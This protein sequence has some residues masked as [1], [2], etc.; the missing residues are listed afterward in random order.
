MMFWMD[1]K[2]FQNIFLDNERD[3]DILKAQYVLIST[4]IRKREAKIENIIT[5]NSILFPDAHVCSSL[6]D[7]DF[8]ERYLN[9][10][11]KNNPFIATLIKGSIEENYNIIFLCTKKENKMKYLQFLSNYIYLEFDYPVYEYKLYASGAIK[12][13]SYNKNKILKKCNKILKEAKDINYQKEIRTTDG[14]KRIIKDFKNM[15]KSDLKKNL[16]KRNLYKEGM[17]K[18]DMIEMIETFM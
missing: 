10:C 12:L 3:Q 2:V 8:K 17:S 16:K 15:K 11:S 6:T 1:S 13:I 5:A 4:R 14:R 9:Q 7:D 18:K